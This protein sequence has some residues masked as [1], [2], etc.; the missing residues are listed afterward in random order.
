MLSHSW[1]EVRGLYLCLALRIYQSVRSRVLIANKIT[2]F[3][4]E[5]P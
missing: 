4:D 3:L 2:N 5:S 1:P